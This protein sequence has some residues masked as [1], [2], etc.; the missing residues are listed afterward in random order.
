MFQVVLFLDRRLLLRCGQN[1]APA[2][3]YDYHPGAPGPIAAEPFCGAVPATVPTIVLS[4]EVNVLLRSGLLV[5]SSNVLDAVIVLLRNVLLARLLSVEE[6]GIIATLTIIFTLLDPSQTTGL[7]RLIVQSR[8]ED[9]KLLD[10]VH[11][12][13]LAFG[14]VM[15][16]LLLLLAW[17][18][19]MAMGGEHAL[20]SY[21]ALGLVPIL[22][23]CCNQD[24]YRHQRRGQFGS[25]VVRQLVPQ[26]LGLAVLWPAFLLTHDHRTTL[27]VMFTQIIATILICNLT[28]EHPFRPRYTP[29]IAKRA[30]R[31]AGPLLLNTFV[32]FAVV[33]GDRIIASNQFGLTV[34]GWFSVAVMVT[35]MPTMLITR[36]MQT[37]LLP[38]L[39]EA[40][41]DP[42]LLQGRNDIVAAAVMFI[43]VGFAAGMAVFGEWFVL[44]VFG[45]KYRPAVPLLVLLAVMNGA[46]LVRA[47][48][49]LTAMAKAETK[50]PLYANLVRVASMPIA[51]VVAIVTR[52]IYWML[53]AGIVGEIIAVLAAAWLGQRMVGV[54][55]GRF[56]RSFLATMALAGTIAAVSSAG[57]SPW[58][59]IPVTAIF[60]FAM[61]DMRDFNK[62]RR[63]WTGAEKRG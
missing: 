49:A 29:E 36:S 3:E 9:T 26:L 2:P 33:N 5:F 34:L 14:G 47:V 17:P 32:M 50:N 44:A 21:L 7:N 20:G 43:L 55:A 10:G 39:A 42:A 40:Q 46:R 16:V 8:E 48:P 18:Y 54:R 30:Y 38:K 4:S 35:L 6:Y 15:A 25:T 11:G 60:L 28:A 52:D 57:L 31:F 22:Y 51:L 37:L 1:Y 41:D 24:V 58:L 23:G 59:L 63:R 61:R 12:L 13:Q 27:F 56:N 45:E 53:V 62:V 19:A